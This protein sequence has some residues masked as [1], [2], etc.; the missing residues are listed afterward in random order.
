MIF[1]KN[2]LDGHAI[3]S[4]GKLLKFVNNHYE[5]EV[6]EEIEMLSAMPCYEIVE[7]APVATPEPEAAPAVTGTQ[8]TTS[9]VLTG[10]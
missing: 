8:A 3:T 1:K 4:S 2:D 6:A 7:A 9:N 10:K 5:T